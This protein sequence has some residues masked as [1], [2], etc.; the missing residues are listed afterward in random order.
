MAAAGS[1]K[2]SAKHREGQLCEDCWEKGFRVQIAFESLGLLYRK[3]EFQGFSTWAE[4]PKR[5]SCKGKTDTGC[6]LWA[7]R[8]GKQLCVFKGYKGLGSRV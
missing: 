7:A 1:N 6:R 8:D 4:S 2:G 3:V 5:R